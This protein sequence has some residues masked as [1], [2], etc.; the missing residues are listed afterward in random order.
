MWPVD[1]DD[2]IRRLMRLNEEDMNLFE[3]L[4]EDEED[5]HAPPLLSF[6]SRRSQRPCRSLRRIP[7]LRASWD[8][9]DGGEGRRDEDGH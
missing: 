9:N 4:T 3:W 8:S 5:S 6:S 1:V 2:R 7:R